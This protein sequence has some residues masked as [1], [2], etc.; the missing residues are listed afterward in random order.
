M[1][2]SGIAASLQKNGVLALQWLCGVAMY[3]E[4]GHLKEQ[5]TLP[6]A[7]LECIQTTNLNS[8]YYN[9]NKIDS[10]SEIFIICLF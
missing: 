2:P 7:G 1:R 5:I 4:T 10:C 8:I 3:W 6:Q 9:N